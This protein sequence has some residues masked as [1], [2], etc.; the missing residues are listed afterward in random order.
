[1]FLLFIPN[2]SI[3]HDIFQLSL[4]RMCK[5]LMNLGKNFCLSLIFSIF[6]ANMHSSTFT[7]VLS[8]MVHN[9]VLKLCSLNLIASQR[10]LL[11]HFPS[12]VSFLLRRRGISLSNMSARI[13]YFCQLVN[14]ETGQLPMTFL[15]FHL[16][17]ENSLP[18]APISQRQVH[19][20]TNYQ[21][22]N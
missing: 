21:E 13:K 19:R 1:M 4:I 20:V 14:M 15:L 22:N 11:C 18:L 3:C 8:V 16:Q 2:S 5:L 6:S 12:P 10:F 17:T 7:G 9:S